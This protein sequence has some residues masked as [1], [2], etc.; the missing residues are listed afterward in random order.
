VTTGV[1]Y[2][3]MSLLCIAVV[4]YAVGMFK[5]NV[6]PDLIAI[7]GLAGFV[8]VFRMVS[9]PPTADLALRA[10]LMGLLIWWLKDKVIALV[11]SRN[12]G[13]AAAQSS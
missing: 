10:A 5:V 6:M 13:V 8:A 2:L 12:P 7:I 3:V 4:N 1:S 11:R 9:L